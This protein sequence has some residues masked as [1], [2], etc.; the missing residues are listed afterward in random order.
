MSDYDIILTMNLA[1]Q[2]R[3]ACERSKLSML[4]ISKRTNLPYQTVHGFMRSD[5]DIVLSSAAKIAELVGVELRSRDKR[6]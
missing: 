5:R 3:R 1:D 2:L 4:Q 6:K